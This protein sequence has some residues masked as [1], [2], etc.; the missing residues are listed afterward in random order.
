[1]RVWVSYYPEDF[2]TLT[3]N[4]LVTNITAYKDLLPLGY[5]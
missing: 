5:T 3:F 2:S 1:M 4:K